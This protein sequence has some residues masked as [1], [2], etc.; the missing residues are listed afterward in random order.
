[1]NDERT[2]EEA[3]E[4][5]IEAGIALERVRVLSLIDEYIQDPEM[6]LE[7]LIESIEDV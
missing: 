7:T 5:G 3:I 1:M 4:Y 2:E 6:D